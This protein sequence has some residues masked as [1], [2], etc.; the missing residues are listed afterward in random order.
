VAVNQVPP[1]KTGKTTG[2]AE[3]DMKSESRRAFG[4][5]SYGQGESVLTLAKLRAEE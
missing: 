1:I 2:A 4:N 5:H 3:I